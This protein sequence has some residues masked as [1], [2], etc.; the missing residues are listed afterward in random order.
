MTT[1][2]STT[3]TTTLAD[4]AVMNEPSELAEKRK[5]PT[6]DAEG[7]EDSAHR[8]TSTTVES[9]AEEGEA[10]RLE[11]P[12]TRFSRE[13]IPLERPQAGWKRAE[14]ETSSAVRSPSPSCFPLPP[15]GRMT[16][17]SANSY[18]RSLV[19]SSTPEDIHHCYCFVRGSDG[20]YVLSTLRERGRSSSSPR[21]RLSLSFSPR[22]IRFLPVHPKH[23]CV[24][25]F[26]S[27]GHQ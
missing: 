9:N 12:Y 15:P 11:D 1:R 26:N 8:P 27:G 7:S 24:R 10:W 2:T 14:E 3:S 18:A 4:P 17:P 21:G 23:C 22:L 20:S 16:D 6:L 13:S 19:F 5:K 25:A